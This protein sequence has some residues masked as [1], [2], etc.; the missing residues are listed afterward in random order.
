[1]AGGPII[2]NL[3]PPPDY[4]LSPDLK[5]SIDVNPDLC[6]YQEVT[7]PHVE[8]LLAI[9]CVILALIL[10]MGVAERPPLK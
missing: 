2:T 3:T 7:L 6:L 9:C 5:C 10:V 8:A 1:M 4:V